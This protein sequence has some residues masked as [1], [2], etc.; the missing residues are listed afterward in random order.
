MPFLDAIKKWFHREWQNFRI[1]FLPLG[2]RDPTVAA[3]DKWFVEFDGEQVAIVSE[4]I[5]DEMF[6]FQWKF[7]SISEPLPA[8]LWLPEND[9]RRAFRH[10]TKGIVVQAIPAGGNAGPM[11][12]NGRVVLRGLYS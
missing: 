3:D 8:G 1:G 10:C 11:L 5:D 2:D 9:E 6:W 7:E 12:P 4:P